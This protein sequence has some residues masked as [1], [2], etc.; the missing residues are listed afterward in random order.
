MPHIQE[1]TSESLRFEESFDSISALKESSLK[2]KRGFYPYTEE[3]GDISSGNERIHCPSLPVVC[4][5]EDTIPWYQWKRKS[6]ATPEER[7]KTFA[8]PDSE[9]ESED[10]FWDA[11]ELESDKQTKLDT[12]Q[13]NDDSSKTPIA[14]VDR[15]HR[16]TSIKDP[17]IVEEGKMFE[18]SLRVSKFEATIHS[19]VNRIL[20]WAEKLTDEC[21]NIKRGTITSIKLRNI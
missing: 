8:V 10:E 1:E 11:Q 17:R 6:F 4:T 18:S 9:S 21:G 7:V 5:F 20:T 14:D 16:C 12:A 3:D 19:G 2:R 13:T 15:C